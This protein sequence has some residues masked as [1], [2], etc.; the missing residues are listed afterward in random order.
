MIAMSTRGKRFFDVVGALGGLIFCAPPMA[1]I[2]VNVLAGEL[3]AVGP[4]PL[5]EGY[6]GTAEAVPYDR[7]LTTSCR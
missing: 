1:A 4:R 2:A 3:S 7:C 6:V 5:T